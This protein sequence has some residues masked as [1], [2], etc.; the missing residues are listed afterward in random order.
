VVRGNQTWKFGGDL[1]VRQNV[2]IDSNASG[3]SKSN[4]AYTTG[5]DVVLSDGSTTN[6]NRN[7]FFS[8]RRDVLGGVVGPQDSGNGYA[9]FLLGYSP[10]ESTRGFPGQP[11]LSSK[12]ISFFVQDDWKVS[13]DLTLNLGLRYDIYTPQTE[14]F[15]NQAN[16]DPA[17]TLLVRTTPDSPHGRGGVETDWNNFGPRIGFAW[18]GLKDDKTV[19]LRGGYGIVYSTDVSGQQPLSSNFLSGGRYD[20]LVLLPGVNIA[21]GAPLPV[22]TLPTTPTFA[23]NPGARVFFNDPEGETEIFHQYNL[24]LQ[25][26]FRPNWMAEAAYVGTRARNLLV[27]R[28]IGSGGGGSRQIPSIGNVILTEFTGSSWYDALQTKLEKRFSRGLS[29]L[30]TYTWSHAIDNTPGGFCV[31]GPDV[32]GQCGPANPII[33]LSLDKGSSDLD[34]RHRFTFSNVWDLPFGRG[35]TFASDIPVGLDYLIGGWQFNNVITIQS[36]PVYS[37]FANGAR[38]DLIGDPFANLPAGVELNRAAF[39]AAVT[40]IFANDPGGPK[41]GSLGRNVFRGQAQEFWDTSLFKN[42]P[43]RFISEDFNVQLRFQFYNV[44]NHINGLR[45][46]RNLNDTTNF[47][48][49]LNTSNARQFEGSIRLVF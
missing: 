29:I 2:N 46:N 42:I 36:G 43:V 20:R 23:P 7:G 18:S 22:A 32:Q 5:A 15:D 44:L 49:D 48:R 31:A 12:E 28:N 17:T 47:G 34:V 9:N 27:V 1:R 10:T 33:G 30:A 37:V 35:R 21:T 40:P 8:G 26:E 16:F 14:R 39:R 25:Y 41:Y 19:V 4:L 24:T 45:P 3:G 11:F 6:L 13:P 38:V